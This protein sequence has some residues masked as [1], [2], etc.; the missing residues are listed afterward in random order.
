MS[1]APVRRTAATRRPSSTTQWRCTP[2]RSVGCTRSCSTGRCS[3]RSPGCPAEAARLTPGRGPGPAGGARLRRPGRR[4]APHRRADHRV[5]PAGGDPAHAAAG[6][7]RLVRRRRRAGRRAAG[8]PP[9]QRGA[10]GDALVPA[11]AAGRD[12]GGRADGLRAGL[13]PVRYRPA[14]ARAG[15]GGACSADDAELVPRGLA[16]LRVGDDGGGQRYD[17]DAEAAASRSGRSAAR[18]CSASPSADVLGTL[19]PAA[20]RATGPMGRR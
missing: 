14:A 7:A 6:A 12:Q 8:V 4:A 18:S 1:P 11:A 20:A 3:T 17:D 13:Q 2:C 19:M 16:A 5:S 10:R 9:G 15:G